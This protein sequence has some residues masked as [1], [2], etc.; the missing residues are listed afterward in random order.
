VRSLI[1]LLFDASRSGAEPDRTPA[2]Y[3]ISSNWVVMSTPNGSS[4]TLAFPAMR[5]CGGLSMFAKRASGGRPTTDSLVV[6]ARFNSMSS[7]RRGC[8][9]RAHPGAAGRSTTRVLL[10]WGTSVS[11]SRT[12]RP[13][14]LFPTERLGPPVI[15]R[16]FHGK[17]R[18]PESA[19][20]RRRCRGEC[21]HGVT[22]ASLQVCPRGS[23]RSRDHEAAGSRGKRRDHHRPRTRNHSAARVRG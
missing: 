11:G 8:I 3:W 4:Q 6:I 23:R 17:A 19:I 10:R 20:L 21:D 9:G 13:F 18:I 12:S 16:A 7:C 2:G 1:E 22:T 15:A 14:L 5:A